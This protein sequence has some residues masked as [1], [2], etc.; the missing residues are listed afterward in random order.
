MGQAIAS[1]ERAIVSGPSPYDYYQQL[2]KFSGVDP[3]D[4][5][6]D[7]PEQYKQYVKAKADAEAHPLSESAQRGSKIYFGT[8]GKCSACH[9]GPNLTDEKYHNLGIGMAAKKPDLGRFEMTKKTATRAP[10]RPRPFA[11]WNC[12][13]PYMHDGT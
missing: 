10:S 7:D 9:V 2:Q 5:K 12:L 8:K 1:F 11:T 6:S 4:L 13:A 3:D